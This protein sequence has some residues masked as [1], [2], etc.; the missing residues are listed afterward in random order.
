MSNKKRLLTYS[1]DDES[2]D[3]DL[4]N[5][6]SYKSIKKVKVLEKPTQKPKRVK[7][8]NVTKPANSKKT[9]RSSDS[10]DEPPV[11]KKIVKKAPP[12]KKIESSESEEDRRQKQ[13]PKVLPPS[14]PYN[15]NSDSSD[16]DTEPPPKNHKNKQTTTTTTTTSTTKP[17]LAKS[18]K[19]KQQDSDISDTNDD[20]DNSSSSSKHL[21][22]LSIPNSNNVNKKLTDIL[23]DLSIYEKNKGLIH[24]FTAYKKAVG[25]I[26]AYP[27]VIKS[28]AEAKKL[29]GVGAKIAKKIQEILDT[30]KLKKLQ[31]QKEDKY[32]TSLN[33]LTRVHGIG[34]QLAKK[35]ITEDDVHSVKDLQKVKDKLNHSQLVGLK[36][37]DDFE[38]R[39]PRDEIEE[40]EVVVAKIL[41]SIDRNIISQVC[42][43]YRRGL[44]S[45]GDIDIL[46]SHPNYTLEMK[47]KKETFKI[48]EKL[49]ERLRK[50]QVIVEDLSLGPFKY[51]GCCI[52]PSK[53]KEYKKFKEEQED[54]DTD[55][56]D[57]KNVKSKK[58]TKAAIEKPIIRRIDFKL[59]PYESY[60]FGLLHATGSD[61]FNRQMRV[62]ALKKGYTLSEYSINKVIHGK[63]SDDDILVDSEKE[64]F[65]IIGM[66]FYKPDQRCL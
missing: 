27:H 58:S 63:K 40:I 59:V 52:V 37:L 33:D 38:K 36:Y 5:V 46:I 7:H 32:L 9:K 44:P 43:S 47:D 3:E 17:T 31:T 60:Y 18:T 50:D 14:K 66:E 61:E 25:S 55:E 21:T 35:F 41:Q 16:S 57:G 53:V 6:T 64:I 19:P 29:E 23:T 65:D 39:V 34:P 62:V 56:E 8:S 54:G 42:G 45:S 30:G 12:K 48:I 2:T 24:K 22:K 26:K 49:V 20:D 15:P 13:I 51:M 11:E 1:S 10:E 4:N 28:G